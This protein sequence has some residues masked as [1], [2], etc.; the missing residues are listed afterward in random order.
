MP[1]FVAILLQ[2]LPYLP[3]VLRMVESIHPLPGKGAEK[4][5]TAVS[6]IQAVVPEVVAHLQNE[7]A[8][9]PKLESLIGTV[10]AGLNAADSWKQNQVPAP[11]FNG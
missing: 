11:S 1:P 2:L 6:V 5:K 7:P 9:K 3:A 4:L 8:N 10:V